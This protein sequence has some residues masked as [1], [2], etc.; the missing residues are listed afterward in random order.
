[1]MT[2]SLWKQL[3]RRLRRTRRPLWTLGGIAFWLMVIAL[4][5]GAAVQLPVAAY[6]QGHESEAADSMLLPQ[7]P[8]ISELLKERD[9]NVQVLLQRQY[10][11]GEE[12]EALGS[13]NTKD[14][15]QL[16]RD[17]PDF[18][19]SLNKD[20]EQ[21]VLVQ[22]IEDLSDYCKSHAYFGVDRFGNFTLF[23]GEP[24]KEKVLRT[25]FQLDIRFM[26]SSLPQHKLERLT[27]GI[28]VSDMD[29][30]NSVLSTFSDYAVNRNE[31]T[32]PLLY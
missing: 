21:V 17:H 12:F 14:I 10:V 4:S 3:K 7:Q 32:K 31:I 22:R 15:I 27:Q 5:A 13:M 20:P 6:A 19:A 23:D 28:R 18:S 11:C 26:E 24:R 25:F 2:F 8:S 1:M 9:K 16:L 30:F 29:E